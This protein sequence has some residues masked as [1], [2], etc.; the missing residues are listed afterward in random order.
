[1]LNSLSEPRQQIRVDKLRVESKIIR[2]LQ[3]LLPAAHSDFRWLLKFP[4]LLRASCENQCPPCS[5]EFLFCTCPG[6]P[7]DQSLQLS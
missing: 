4:T 6:Y 2:R 3:K 1:M 5:R 7:G